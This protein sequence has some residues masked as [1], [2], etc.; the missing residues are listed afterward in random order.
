[1]NTALEERIGKEFDTEKGI[2]SVRNDISAA[3]FELK[4][5]LSFFGKTGEGKKLLDVG[6]GKGIFTAA[7]KA[8]GYDACGIEL[9]D[10]LLRIAKEKNSGM[11][12]RKGSATEIPFPDE[13]FD[14]LICVEV[15]EHVPDTDAALKEFSR[16]LR[17]GG[18]M[19]IID[20]NR[21]SLHPGY[22]IPTALWKA[23]LERRNKWMYSRDFPFKEK[24]FSPSRLRAGIKKY[25]SDVKV[26]FLKTPVG[27][28]KGFL[29]KIFGIVRRALAAAIH[30]LLPFLDFHVS[31]RGVK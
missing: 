22:F 4:E 5:I 6:C 26:V 7:L 8:R 17:S 20:K 3:E 25:F 16:V 19:I 27:M 24:Y 18:K 28:G 12:F 21:Y 13:S 30:A 29:R 1:M 9:S 14:F 23:F 11:D 10:E 2:G 31:W 15:L